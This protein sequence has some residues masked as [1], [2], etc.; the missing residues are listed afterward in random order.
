ML[1]VVQWTSSTTVINGTK[2]HFKF[3]INFGHIIWQKKTQMCVNN[4]THLVR[5]TYWWS[6]CNCSIC[7]FA[8]NYWQITSSTVKS[9]ALDKTKK[10]V[11]IGYKKNPYISWS[12]K[13]R[14]PKILATKTL[15]RIRAYETIYTQFQP[16]RTELD[17]E[18]CKGRRP[19]K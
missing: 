3:G 12:S 4:S 14:R 17:S 16:R 9:V 15:L 19:V 7:N 10:A 18:K 5:W 2:Q 13:S 8:W 6:T 1:G 11:K